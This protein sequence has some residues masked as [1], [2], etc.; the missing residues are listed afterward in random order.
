[1]APTTTTAPPGS[2]ALDADTS[3]LEGAIGHWASW[4]S[5]TIS[6]TTAQA[7]SGTRSLQ[8]DITQLHGWGVTLDN[9]PGFVATPGNKAIGFW[10]RSP[11][12]G[13]SVTMQVTWR[14]TAGT[15]LQTDVATRT[16][17]NTWQQATANLVAPAGT[18]R[19]LVDF[20][21]TTGGPGST[22]FLDDMVVNNV[23]GGPTTTSTVPSPTTTVVP[24]GLNALDAATS[25]LEAGAGHWATWFSANISRTTAQA[26]GGT[27][28]LQV[29]I[30]QL[31][32]WGVTLDNWPGFVAT[33]GTKT[34][35][36]WARSPGAGL[37]V[38]MQVTWRNAAGTVLRT[39]LLDRTLADSWR[40]AAT[41]VTAPAGTARVL[42]EFY[43]ASGGP[44]TTIYLDD[45]VV[46]DP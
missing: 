30:T 28:S 36:F 2:N 21:H 5:T 18:T 8:V 22:V 4:F 40:Q 26:H 10:A 14:N 20:F 27:R 9:W 17:T 34:I 31:H 12:A 6:R 23:G 41:T 16:L 7:H 29:D 44:G 43:N 37:T 32:G 19:V 45:I 39:D 3:A 13:L 35:A 24:G 33:P 15:V 46:A 38:T 42:V 1:V 25:T 11:N